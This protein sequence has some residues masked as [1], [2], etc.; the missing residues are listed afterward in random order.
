MAAS[1]FGENRGEEPSA[2]AISPS[3]WETVTWRPSPPSTRETV[4][5]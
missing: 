3:L 5:R 1:Y 2:L 4:A